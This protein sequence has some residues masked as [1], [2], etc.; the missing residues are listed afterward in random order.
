MDEITGDHPCVDFYL[1][2]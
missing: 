1:I 2:D